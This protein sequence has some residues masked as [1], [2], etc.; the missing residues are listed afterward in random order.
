MRDGRVCFIDYGMMGFILESDKEMKANLL[1]A[2]SDKDVE[3][4]KI[5]LIKFTRGEKFDNEKDLEYDIID[6][7]NS[8]STMTIDEIDGNEVMQG[9]Q[10]MF[11]KYKIRVPSNMLLLLKALVIIEGVGLVLDPKYNIIKNIDPFVR[12]LLAKKYAPKKLARNMLKAIGGFSNMA[13]NL[14]GDI[15]A[16]FRKIRQ[17]KLHIEFEHKGLEKLYQKM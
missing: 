15:E 10:R 2:I 14:P 8:Y 5:A 6:F 11:F 9:L 12:R 3:A 16:V 7:L 17:G 1:L 13:V 4:L